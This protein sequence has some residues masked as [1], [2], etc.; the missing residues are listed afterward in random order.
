MAP[1]RPPFDLFDQPAARPSGSL[2][3]SDSRGQPANTIFCGNAA[4]QVVTWQPLQPSFNE[5][6]VLANQNGWVR[7]LA[8][9][10]KFVVSAGGRTVRVWDATYVKPKR[11]AKL[12]VRTEVAI[13]TAGSG[14]VYAAGA[15][16]SLRAWSIDR[17]TGAL[18]ELAA[19]E[20]AH[21]GRVVGLRRHKGRLYS[22]SADGVLRAWC[23]D[24]LAPVA[25]VGDAAGG[26]KLHCM[27]FAGNGVLYTGGDDCLIRAWDPATLTPLPGCEPLAVH[28]SA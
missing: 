4:K 26:G 23:A 21:K 17:D 19:V 27:A 15:D 2:P 10:D 11:V 6:P 9:Y 12:E 24:D 20:G 16:G 13:L 22:A 8:T 1:A 25:H 14:R 3:P 5:A 7:A 28:T 18:S